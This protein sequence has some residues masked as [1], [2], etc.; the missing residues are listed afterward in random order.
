MS[1][2]SISQTAGIEENIRVFDFKA[3]KW[4]L[5]VNYEDT[6]TNIEDSVEAS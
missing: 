5:G 2:T 6:F 1:K 4:D 3:K